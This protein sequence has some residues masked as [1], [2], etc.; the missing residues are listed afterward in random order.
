VVTSPTGSLV[1]ITPTTYPDRSPSVDNDVTI[2]MPIPL[3]E[4]QIP[5]ISTSMSEVFRWISSLAKLYGEPLS[6]D[7]S[8]PLR[9]MT[10]SL[11]S[12]EDFTT[13]STRMTVGHI[14]ST[15]DDLGTLVIAECGDPAAG[16]WR[17]RLVWHNRG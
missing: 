13:W 7:I 10:I 15:T 17:M 16:S 2:V 14:R 12:H 6:V 1:M 3:T 4:F 9:E 8:A 5:D 11:P